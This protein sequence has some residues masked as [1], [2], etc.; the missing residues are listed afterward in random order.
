VTSN[1]RAQLKTA[2]IGLPIFLAALMGP[3]LID[4]ALAHWGL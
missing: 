2:L 1:E 4:R 3:G